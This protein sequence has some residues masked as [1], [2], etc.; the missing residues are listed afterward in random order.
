MT[1]EEAKNVLRMKYRT[2]FMATKE[3]SFKEMKEE[4]YRLTGVAFFE[5]FA[6][7][8]TVFTQP[9]IDC[10]DSYFEAANF[11]TAVKTVTTYWMI[12]ETGLTLSSYRHFLN[13]D[14]SK[15][16]NSPVNVILT[17]FNKIPI[18]KG[19]IK[20]DKLYGITDIA[21]LSFS[22]LVGMFNMA[23]DRYES[24]NTPMLT[25]NNNLE[26]VANF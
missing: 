14:T 5:Y 10:I 6:E 22:S 9:C 17:P 24:Q 7:N 25:S 19:C 18:H 2:K 4:L 23:Y 11:V 13:K 26:D 15:I 8:A 3:A 12:K 16:E 1:H 21:E 20:S